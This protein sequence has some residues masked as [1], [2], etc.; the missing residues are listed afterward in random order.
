MKSTTELLFNVGKLD[1]GEMCCPSAKPLPDGVRLRPSLLGR[2]RPGGKDTSGDWNPRQGGEGRRR[3]VPTLLIS[4]CLPPAFSFQGGGPFNP[5]RRRGSLT[6]YA[7]PF[8]F[9]MIEKFAWSEWPILA[10][11]PGGCDAVGSRF[12]QSPFPPPLRA[13]ACPGSRET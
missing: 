5:T 12:E 2:Q 4:F 13:L 6:S 10:Q 9:P 11:S 8:P 3:R 7:H 1:R